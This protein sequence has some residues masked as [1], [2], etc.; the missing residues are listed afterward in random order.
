VITDIAGWWPE[1]PLRQR[2]QAA[3]ARFRIP[4]WDWAAKPPSGQSVLPLSVGVKTYIT[5]DGPYGPQAISNPLFTYY[6]N[7]F[8]A[9]AFYLAPVSIVLLDGLIAADEHT[10]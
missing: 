1:G 10:G 8:N 2:Y 3:A 4:Y 5:V 9:T 6:F 7:P